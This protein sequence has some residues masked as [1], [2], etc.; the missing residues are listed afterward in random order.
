MEFQ[1]CSELNNVTIFSWNWFDFDFCEKTKCLLMHSVE[2]KEFHCHDF[3]QN[4]RENNFFTKLINNGSYVNSFHEIFFKWQQ[5]FTFFH[6]VSLLFDSMKNISWNQ[7][8]SK[9]MHCF[10][11]ISEKRVRV[12]VSGQNLGNHN[13]GGHYSGGQNG[14]R[15]K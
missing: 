7:F 4:F 1:R 11:E 12:E 5:I 13:S 10:H 15:T 9:I 3:S 6:V 8:S 14:E 2:I